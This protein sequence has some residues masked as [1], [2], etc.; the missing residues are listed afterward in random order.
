MRYLVTGG[1]GF[2]GSHLVDHLVAAGQEVVVLDDLS[3]GSRENVA[4]VRRRIGFIRGSVAELN[5]CWRAMEGVDCVLHQAALTSEQRSVEAPLATHEVNST[6]T[7]NVLVAA[8]EAG[9]RRVVYASSTAVYGSSA[10]LPNSETQLARP[11][12]PYAA[13]KLAGEEYCL[14]FYQENRRDRRRRRTHPVGH[15]A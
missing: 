6:G 1:A 11:L 8:C 14:A 15:A 13:T 12:G 4:A 10:A 7:L 9:V 5:I 3:S 2:I